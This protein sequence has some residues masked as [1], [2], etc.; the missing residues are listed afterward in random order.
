MADF[1]LPR[2]GIEARD[3]RSTVNRLRGNEASEEAAE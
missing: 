2:L 3:A 1:A